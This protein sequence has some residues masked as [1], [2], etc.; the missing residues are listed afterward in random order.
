MKKEAKSSLQD[1]DDVPKIVIRYEAVVGSSAGDHE[2]SELVW[3]QEVSTLCKEVVCPD[4]K[5]RQGT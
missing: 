3:M 2:L 5:S 4:D 1:V